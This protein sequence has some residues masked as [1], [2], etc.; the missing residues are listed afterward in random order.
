MPRHLPMMIALATIT[1]A[2]PASAQGLIATH[3]IPAALA[4][5]AVL[6]EMS[7]AL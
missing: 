2:A 3:R 6:K 4:A 5:E 7:H 1:L